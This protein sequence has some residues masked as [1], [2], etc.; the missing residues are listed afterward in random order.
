MLRFQVRLKIS[1]QIIFFS[2]PFPCIGYF[3]A[4]QYKNVLICNRD[5]P[6]WFFNMYPC[7]HCSLSFLMV[8]CASLCVCV[9]CLA[10][11]QVNLQK[12]SQVYHN[13]LTKTNQQN[14]ANKLK[15][16]K[17]GFFAA[18]K[19]ELKSIKCLIDERREENFYKFPDLFHFPKA[20][21]KPFV[22]F[23]ILLKNGTT[24]F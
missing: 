21:L 10:K 9:C 6:V 14:T 7:K 13:T 5:V 20:R 2:I 11:E 23:I 12:G 18:R 4:S 1:C 15:S 19:Q 8:L 17:K 16:K 24:L 3:A 22:F